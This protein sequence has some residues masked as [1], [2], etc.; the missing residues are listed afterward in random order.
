MAVFTGMLLMAFGTRTGH[1]IG[2]YVPNLQIASQGNN[3]NI[4]DIKDLGGKYTLLHFWS[5]EDATSRLNNKKYE[6]S[7]GNDDID[8]GINYIAINLDAN[9]KLGFEIARLDGLNEEY[10]FR[11]VSNREKILKQFDLAKGFKSFLIDA[12]GE[13]IAINPP[14]ERLEELQ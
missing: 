7:L 14:L 1:K 4:I 10:Q 12:K 9:H 3:S 8:K 13:I 6:I 5:S 11:S 2:N